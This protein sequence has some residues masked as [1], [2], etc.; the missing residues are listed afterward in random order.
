MIVETHRVRDESSSEGGDRHTMCEMNSRDSIDR[1]EVQFS[2]DPIM[3]FER[4]VSRSRLDK[5]TGLLTSD[6]ASVLLFVKEVLDL[7]IDN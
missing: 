7:G 5:E 1:T 6:R 4:P 3:M 2:A